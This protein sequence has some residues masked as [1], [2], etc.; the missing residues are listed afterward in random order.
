[1]LCYVYIYICVNLFEGEY[2]SGSALFC[3]YYDSNTNMCKT[4]WSQSQSCS[5]LLHDLQSNRQIAILPIPA[6]GI[7]KSPDNRRNPRNVHHNLPKQHLP[8]ARIPRIS[9]LPRPSTQ[10]S[11]N[12]AYHFKLSNRYF[13][14]YICDIVWNWSLFFYL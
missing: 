10:L 4:N 2:W 3:G 7:H 9:S 5:Q 13:H 11:K 8:L 1:M 14:T 6:M 12:V